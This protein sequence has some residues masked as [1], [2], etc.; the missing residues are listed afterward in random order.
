MALDACPINKLLTL[1]CIYP[2]RIQ[3]QCDVKVSSKCS[4]DGLLNDLSFVLAG[5][6]II[7]DE[8]LNCNI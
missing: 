4:V 1:F 7:S 8:T 3:R 5:E 2:K 6:F